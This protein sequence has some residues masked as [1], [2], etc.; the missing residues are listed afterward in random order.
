MVE[1]DKLNYSYKMKITKWALLL[2][3]LLVYLLGITKVWARTVCVGKEKR[4]CNLSCNKTYSELKLLVDGA[5][6]I[7]DNTT[8]I[9]LPGNHSLSGSDVDKAL[10]ILSDKNNL[11]LKGIR[12]GEKQVQKTYSPPSIVVCSGNQSG[13]LF[14]NSSNISINN[15]EFQGCRANMNLT[16]CGTHKNNSSFYGGV[17]F[18]CSYHITMSGVVIRDG[19][20]FGLH[21]DYVCGNIS[22]TCSKF[23]GNM[24]G[25]AVLW[26]KQCANNKEVNNTL[27]VTDSEFRNG[28]INDKKNATGLYLLIK[29][30]HTRASLKNLKFSNNTGTSGGN[31]AIRFIDFAD[32]TGYVSIDDTVIENGVAEDGGGML[33]WFEKDLTPDLRDCQN[34]SNKYNVLTITNTT[35]INNTARI[36]GGGGLFLS[37]YEITGVGCTNRQVE[38]NNCTLK[39]NTAIRGSAIEISKHKV[40]IYELHN[41]PQFT[42][43][44]NNSLITNNRLTPKKG[45]ANE[46]G[47]V[48]VFSVASLVIRNT[49]FSNNN[50]T[51]LMLVNSGVQFKGSITFEG[52]SARYGGAIKICDSSQM[53]FFNDTRV[54]FTD[55]T[56]DLA[57]GAIYA[58][59]QCLQETPPCVFQIP[60]SISKITD[61]AKG[62]LHF[63]GNRAGIAGHAIY[64]GTV[65]DCFTDHELKINQSTEESSYYYSFELYKR[66]FDFSNPK[67]QSKVTSD[68]YGVCECD[69]NNKLQCSNRTIVREK[70]NGQTF[71]IYVSAVGQTNGK[72]PS[73]LEVESDKGHVMMAPENSSINQSTALCREM[74]LQIMA[75]EEFIGQNISVKIGIFKANLVSES[76]NYYK[77]PKLEVNV[78]LLSCP[79]LFQLDNKNSCNCKAPLDHM[80]VVCDID[81]ETFTIKGTN[82]FEH[83]DSKIWIGFDNKTGNNYIEVSKHCQLDHCSNG[84]T[85][86]IH[87]LSMICNDGRQG[88]LCGSCQSNYTLSLGVMTCVDTESEC[89]QWTTVALI[90]AFILAGILLVCFLTT[91]NFTVAEGTVHGLL[92]YA[93]C[94]QANFQSFFT[95]SDKDYASTTFISWLNLDFGFTVCFYSGMTAYQKI[96]LEFGFLIYLLLLGAMI[97]CLSRRFVWFT[98]LAGR[99]VVPVLATIVLF[100][101]PKLVRNS[102]K[103][104]ECHNNY[105]SSGN[106]TPLVWF[107]DETVYCFRGKH[108]AL[109]LFSLVLFTIASWYMLCL[110]LIQCLQKRSSWFVLRWVNK[111]R[112]FFD[113]NTGTYHDHNR[114]WPGLLL[115]ARLGLYLA[116]WRTD[117][118]RSKTQIILAICVFLFF[119][120]CV[121]PRGVYKKW[122]LNILEFSFIF[123]L[124]LASAAVATLSVDV[125][126]YFGWTSIGIAAFTFFLIIGFHS[127]KKAS[128]T[129]IWRRIVA[130]RNTRRNRFIAEQNTESA[131]NENEP[132]LHDQ[133]LP[134]VIQFATPREP[135]LEDD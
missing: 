71:S 38:I 50:G 26:F 103:V 31:I 42:V 62:I 109:F 79:L 112:P 84:S 35:F 33:I 73:R 6:N 77:I 13:F 128:G 28:Y 46:D 27:T 121:F 2:S 22:I 98:R 48:E 12:C 78:T 36:G 86:N 76:S 47:I 53:Y 126:K 56:A 24:D 80:G 7:I 125:R 111:L 91:F 41:V 5:R 107:L 18:H 74:K 130:R 51:G 17:F 16:S 60:P 20:G 69:V 124:G 113:A 67:E 106:Q 25:N 123:N 45:Q 101:Y 90:F 129:R 108:L 23:I 117:G 72:V 10:I 40:P 49:N 88:R 57:G 119:L 89:N 97:V 83:P 132:L 39:N 94:M 11:T 65:D 70:Y 58:G 75:G 95:S 127:Y 44:L 135:L 63:D 52:N 1:T 110:L 93:N 61:M 14:T 99:N 32:H 15:L 59:N 134:R 66:I 96:W 82:D 30:R 37:Y 102:I 133:R 81:T 3:I 19:K 34:K 116:L 55:N 100:A 9:F 122:P 68:P 21:M 29:Q 118:H 4:S 105:K 115:F 8:I 85:L 114:F 54:T 43:T 87:N 120:A 64:G 104:W 131:L 92:F